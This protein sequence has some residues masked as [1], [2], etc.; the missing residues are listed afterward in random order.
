VVRDDLVQEGAVGLLRALEHYDPSLGV[1]FE[2]YAR[3]RVRR[4]IRNA[5]TEQARLIRLP[6]QVVDR[7]RL[8]DRLEAQLAASGERPTTVDLAAESGLSLRSVLE[9]RSAPHVPLSLDEPVQTDGSPLQS[10][11]AD[12]AAADPAAHALARER[13]VLVHE[14]IRN[15]SNRKR[16]AVTARFGMDGAEPL[17]SAQLAR[18][19]RLSPRRTQ[20]ITSDALADLA[21]EL[22]PAL[23]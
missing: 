14:A 20:T 4:A 6:K 3:F 16:R 18:E 2:T 9:A 23:R 21:D 11:L 8:L 19:L 1:D 12:P 13:Q 22:E 7:K 10:L 5:L 15:L 17:T